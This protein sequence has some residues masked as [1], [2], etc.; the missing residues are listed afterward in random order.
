MHGLPV[1][2]FSSTGSDFPWF[3][4]LSLYEITHHSHACVCA[5]IQMSVHTHKVLLHSKEDNVRCDLAAV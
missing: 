5:R 1:Q 2:E 4:S 3:L